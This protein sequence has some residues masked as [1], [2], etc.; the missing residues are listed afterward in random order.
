MTNRQ[1]ELRLDTPGDYRHYRGS[2]P[3]SHDD[4]SR[5]VA[6]KTRRRITGLQRRV[7]FALRDAPSGL[8]LDD[9]ITVL[10]LGHGSAGTRLL[11]LRRLGVAEW[12]GYRMTTRGNRAH[13]NI[14]TAAGRLLADKL[15]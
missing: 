3:H 4:T 14:L 7:L 6:E 2:P 12:S 15:R 11:E 10:G 13:V 8:T 9:T 5:E 1:R